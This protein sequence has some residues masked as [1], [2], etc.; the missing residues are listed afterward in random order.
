MKK[1]AEET[2]VGSFELFED[3]KFSDS[4]ESATQYKSVLVK[5][6]VYSI[7]VRTSLHHWKYVAVALTGTC[8]AAGYGPKRYKEREGKETT[9]TL[10]PYKY[11]LR[12]AEKEGGDYFGGR[13]K[14]WDHETLN[15]AEGV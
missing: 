14:I 6:G 5:K 3:K 8:V 4:F 12:N 15:S 2:W 7:Y 9:L 13:V 11:L 10:L 1:L